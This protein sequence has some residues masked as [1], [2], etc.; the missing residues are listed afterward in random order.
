MKNKKFDCVELQDQGALRIYKRTKDMT[1]E[2][3][4]AFWHEQHQALQ[5]RQTAAQRKYSKRRRAV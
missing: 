3:Q 4:L 5:K 1:F 2:E